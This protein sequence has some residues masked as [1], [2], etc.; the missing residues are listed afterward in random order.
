MVTPH[1]EDM[2]RTET[3]YVNEMVAGDGDSVA[4][5]EVHVFAQPVTGH[6]VIVGTSRKMLED[7]LKTYREGC[8]KDYRYQL[9]L[10]HHIM[11]QL[12]PSNTDALDEQGYQNFCDDVVILACMREALFGVAA[13]LVP[14]PNLAVMKKHPTDAERRKMHWF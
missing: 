2:R 3:P 4:T 7:T 10:Y 11:A 13:P 14:A 1:R 6:M 9:G 12:P 8:A 5:A